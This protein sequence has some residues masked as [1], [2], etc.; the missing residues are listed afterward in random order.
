LQVRNIISMLSKTE[1]PTCQSD[2][3]SITFCTFCLRFR[4]GILTVAAKR[5]LKVSTREA[6]TI[7]KRALSAE[8]SEMA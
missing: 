7:G 6:R 5:G 3:N 2:I 4:Q 1:S 8:D